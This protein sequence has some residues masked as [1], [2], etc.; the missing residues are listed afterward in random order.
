MNVKKAETAP[1]LE[2]VLKVRGNEQKKETT[3]P[4]AAKPT[5]QT[6]CPIPCQLGKLVSAQNYLPDMVFK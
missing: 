5:V 1:A 3:A 2:S 4:M 6:E